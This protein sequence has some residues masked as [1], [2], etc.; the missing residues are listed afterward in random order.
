MTTF[1]ILW[2]L[3]E[4]EN[5]KEIDFFDQYSQNP[6]Y[7]IILIIFIL[8]FLGISVYIRK[9]FHI[10]RIKHKI[11]IILCC[12]NDKSHQQCE[13]AFGILFFSFVQSVGYIV[14]CVT[15][16]MFG[17]I[18]V[19]L[20]SVVLVLASYF[21]Y[22]ANT[23]IKA[24]LNLFD[25]SREQDKEKFTKHRKT[26]DRILLSSWALI[27]LLVIQIVSLVI[28][29]ISPQLFH[30]AM[31]ITEILFHLLYLIFVLRFYN[32]YV[33]AKITDKMKQG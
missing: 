3:E 13:P 32:D 22:G 16:L 8:S 20:L 12:V 4:T 7:A 5:D 28:F 25:T 31:Q 23:T 24:T 9:L 11:A 2:H 19:F 18:Y 6:I 21:T 14:S 15:F 30:P 1:G 29:M 17:V 10:L 27:V 26:L 33:K